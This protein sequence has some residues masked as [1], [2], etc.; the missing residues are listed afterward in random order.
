MRMKVGI[1]RRIGPFRAGISTRGI[2]AGAGPVSVGHA[3]RRPRKRTK[4]V[5]KTEETFWWLL[6]LGFLA[7]A[8]AWLACTW[9]WYLTHWAVES[10]GG[11]PTTSVVLATAAESVYLLAALGVAAWFGWPRARTWITKAASDDER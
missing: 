9:P 3:W 5:S 4:P 8:A 11:S 1:G 7:L 6:V 10:A 2:G